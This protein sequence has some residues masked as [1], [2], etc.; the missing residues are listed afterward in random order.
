[1]SHSTHLQDRVRE[2]RRV[3]RQWSLLQAQ[4]Q[5]GDYG[6]TVM[7]PLP[8]ATPCPACPQPGVN[9]PTNWNEVIPVDK[10]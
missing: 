9:I 2:F 10:Q 3:F 6:P 5:C 7:A 1:M 8:M 4:K